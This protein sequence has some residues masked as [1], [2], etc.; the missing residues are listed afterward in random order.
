MQHKKIL[1]IGKFQMLRFLIAILCVIAPYNILFASQ[2]MVI[3]DKNTDNFPEVSVNYFVFDDASVLP[4]H[5]IQSSQ[6]TVLDNGVNMPVINHTNYTG[7]LNKSVSL[8]IC[9]DLGLNKTNGNYK[10][11]I[12]IINYLLENFDF[13]Q[14]EVALSAFD[15]YT[16]L[17]KDFT[18]DKDVLVDAVKLYHLSTGSDLKNIFMMS[19]G[20]ITKVFEKGIYSKSSLII[21]DGNSNISLSTA[22]KQ[23]YLDGNIQLNIISIGTIVSDDLKQLVAATDGIVLENISTSVPYK[24]YART[25]LANIYNISPASLTWDASSSCEDV[26]NTEIYI[27]TTNSESGLKYETSLASKR[28]LAS[29]PSNIKFNPILPGNFESKEIVIEAVN[30]EITIDKITLENDV[31]FEITEGAISS[32]LL[33]DEG[34]QHKVKVKYTPVDSTIQFTKLLIQSTACTGNEILIAA[35]YPNT[36]PKEKTIKLTSPDCN[37]T[38]ILGEE[39]YVE[40]EGLLPE[41]VIQLEYSLDDGKNWLPLDSNVRGLKYKWNLPQ[42]ETDEALVKIIQLWPNNVGQTMD[43]KHWAQVNSASFN[44]FGDRVV[45]ASSD[46]SAIVWNSNTGVKILTLA[47][48]SNDVNYAVFSNDGKYIATASKD[49]TVILWDATT[50]DSLGTVIQS[51]KI[52]SVNFSHNSK[53]FVTATSDGTV[54]IY[55]VKTL[56]LVLNINA[57]TS[58][59][60]AWYAEFDPTD[61]YV[62]AAG[63]SVYAKI[64]NVVGTN[65]GT[66]YKSFKV[67]E[68]DYGDVAHATFNDN[69]TKV[70]LTSSNLKRTIVW[71]MKNLPDKDTYFIQDSLYSVSHNKDTSD[72]YFIRHASFSRDKDGVEYLLTSGTDKK[73]YVW[74][75]ADGTLKIELLEHRSTVSTAVM[76]FDGSRVLTASWDSTAKVWN[77]DKRDLQMDTTDCTFS[78]KKPNITLNDLSYGDIYRGNVIDSMFNRVIVNDN[79]FPIEVKSITLNNDAAEQFSLISKLDL[80]I[81][82]MPTEVIDLEFSIYPRNSGNI[83]GQI[84]IMTSGNATFTSEI[85]ANVLSEGLIVNNSYIDLGLVDFGEF[86][87]SILTAVVTNTNSVDINITDIKLD[88]PEPDNFKI[89][90]GA[91]ISTISPGKSKTFKVRYT[92]SDNLRNNAVLTVSHDLHQ[93]PARINLL[94]EGISPIV[95]S[96]TIYIPDVTGAPGDI[97]Q[98]PI[99]IKNIN[100]EGIRKTISGITTYLSFNATLL[101]PVD[102]YDYDIIENNVRTI[103]IDLPLSFGEDS[104]LSTIKFHVGLGNSVNSEMTLKNS[105]P[106]GLGKFDIQE[107]SSVFTLTGFCDD[108]NPRLFDPNGKSILAQNMPNPFTTEANVMFELPKDSHV[109]FYVVDMTGKTVLNIIDAKLEKGEHNIHIDASKLGTG[110]YRYILKTPYKIYSR[111]MQI[112]K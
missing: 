51:E 102:T 89:I 26:H 104:T 74:Y 108:D 93:Y 55:D 2:N 29:L 79:T 44:Q 64:Y 42:I 15:T 33:L 70:A 16:F 5:D 75:A 24:D 72:N 7:D 22:Q 66:L 82:L 105:I 53:V 98:L 87:D 35:G 36:P 78:I 111:T 112:I 96:C 23:A 99:K 73:A 46:S 71:D 81:I 45:T 28:R 54:K 39:H 18:Q 52:N 3:L 27:P 69:A 57:Y 19:P 1:I 103:G 31:L 12:D 21:T 13:A 20:A 17:C 86:K 38:L 83:K 88:V 60:R 30:G 84:E 49:S 110:I 85:T 41:D 34:D 43:L 63:N 25:I 76:N 47:K 4:R 61:S 92:P 56:A 67:Q 11:G 62:L 106:I 68:A 9:F 32:S 77:L 100:E 8:D 65:A 101:A 94:G 48:H 91:D 90:E 6:I 37:E 58:T 97:I 95:S 109:K 50:G 40:W 107:E 10:Y 14:A 59:K 80:P